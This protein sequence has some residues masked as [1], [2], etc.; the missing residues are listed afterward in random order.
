MDVYILKIV[1]KILVI[2][3]NKLRD[4]DLELFYILDEKKYLI[5]KNKDFKFFLS[6]NNINCSDEEFQLFIDKLASWYFVK[7]P[8]ILF[9]NQSGFHG[10]NSAM[11][12]EKLFNN[13]NYFEY[14]LINFNSLSSKESDIYESLTQYL[15]TLVGYKL[16][17]SKNSYPEY[18]IARTEFMFNEFNNYFGWN[19]SINIYDYIINKNYSTEKSFNAYLLEQL[20]D[21]QTKKK[22]TKRKKLFK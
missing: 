20:K 12:L 5:S 4:N 21:N 6:T 15:L 3:M 14:K 8:D 7:L 2:F 1:L 13:L 19:L 11:T 18:G 22:N 10:Y 17:Y 16:I 9:Q